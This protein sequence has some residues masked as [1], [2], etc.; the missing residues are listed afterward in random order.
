MQIAQADETGE[1]AR[2][3]L[4]VESADAAVEMSP[5]QTFETV[6]QGMTAATPMMQTML[7]SAKA[8]VLGSVPEGDVQHVLYRMSMDVNGVALSQVEVISFKEHEGQWRAM[9]TGDMDRPMRA[10]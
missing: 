1:M 6:M 3:F 9:L 4:G 10:T 8:D 7:Q 5:A 2:M